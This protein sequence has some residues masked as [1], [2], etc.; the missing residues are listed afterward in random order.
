M[1]EKNQLFTENLLR[2]FSLFLPFYIFIFFSFI[3][4]AFLLSLLL[5]FL[6]LFLPF[7]LTSTLGPTLP[8]VQWKTG[9]LP[10][11]EATEM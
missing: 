9:V 3:F 7:T 5:M 2:Q 1:T 4:F 10:Q 8:P 6:L 11:G